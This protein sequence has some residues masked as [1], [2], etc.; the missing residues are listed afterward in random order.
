M[1]KIAIFIYISE[2]DQLDFFAIFNKFI[3]NKSFICSMQLDFQ[4][5]LFNDSVFY[6]LI[7]CFNYLK[8]VLMDMLEFVF[9]NQVKIYKYFL[10]SYVLIFSS[11]ILA[12]VK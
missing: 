4:F 5:E 10:M 7:F 1:I 8:I 2:L 12:S 9:E 6:L 11:L 3:Q